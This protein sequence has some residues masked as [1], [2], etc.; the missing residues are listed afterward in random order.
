[1]QHYIYVQLNTGVKEIIKLNPDGPNYR[2]KHQVLV[3]WSRTILEK[4]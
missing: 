2:D 4:S 3:K 1:M